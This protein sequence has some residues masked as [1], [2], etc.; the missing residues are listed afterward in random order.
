MEIIPNPKIMLLVFV[1][2]L[3][4]MF[5][6]NKFVF[7][8][9]ISYMDERE[10]KVSKDLELVSSDDSQSEQIEKEI[11][12]IL[13]KAKNEAYA[14]KEAEISK[15]KEA[16]AIKIEKIQS[17]NKEKMDAFLAKLEANKEAMKADIKASLGDIESLLVTKIKQI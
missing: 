3:I 1:V 15:A 12:E 4:T 11:K 10:K 14:L 9:L 6:L 17:E 16:A 13:T 8:P 7:V 2:F 5:L